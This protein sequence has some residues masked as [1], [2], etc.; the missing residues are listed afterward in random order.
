MN[1][2]PLLGWKACQAP[3]NSDFASGIDKPD[4]FER[5]LYIGIGI[6]FIAVTAVSRGW[7]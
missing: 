3:H 2:T 6:M 1:N 4:W 7:L 5:A